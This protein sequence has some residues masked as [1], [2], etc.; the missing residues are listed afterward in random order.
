MPWGNCGA[1]FPLVTFRCY[2]YIAGDGEGRRQDPVHAAVGAGGAAGVPRV[3]K[4]VLAWLAGVVGLLG[5]FIALPQYAMECCWSHGLA[6]HH[7]AGRVAS[8][9]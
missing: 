5:G 3:S 2:P 1:F 8:A 7:C 9:Q 6:V 4:H